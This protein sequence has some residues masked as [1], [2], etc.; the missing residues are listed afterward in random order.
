MKADLDQPDL[1]LVT[2]LAARLVAATPARRRWHLARHIALVAVLPLVT[3]V[4]LFVLIWHHLAR[5]R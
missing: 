2:N 3:Q 5:K 1:V 4:V